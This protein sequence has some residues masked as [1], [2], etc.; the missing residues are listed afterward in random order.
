MSKLR[1]LPVALALFLVLP[2]TLAQENPRIANE[3]TIGDKWMLADGATLATAIYP[4]AFARSGENVCVALGY[5]IDED[6]ATS[7]FKV[8]KQWNNGS[9]EREPVDGFWQAFAQA[10]ADAV[11]QWQFKQ[12]PEVQVVRPT[13]TV[14][15]LGFGGAKDAN[16][17]EVRMHCKIGDLAD[18]LQTMKSE[19]FRRGDMNTQQFETERMREQQQQAEEKL[20]RA[21]GD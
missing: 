7:D 11:S 15:T 5:L 21:N 12:R 13:Y 3:G 2:T 8:L 9:G 1:S 17:A 20:R 6:G 10:S 14:A 18:H 4:P 19:A 16:L